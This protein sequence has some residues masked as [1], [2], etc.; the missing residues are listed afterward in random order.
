[1]A[2]ITRRNHGSRRNY[3]LKL[4]YRITAEEVERHRR[5]QGGVCSICL[6]RKASHVDHDH[7]TGL[8]RG[9]LCFPCNGALGQYHDTPE[10]LRA[11][12]R[13][14]EGT[15]FHATEMLLEFGVVTLG[16][17]ARRLVDGGGRRIKRAGTS[18]DDHLR[19]RYGIG[20]EQVQKLLALQHGRCAAC[21]EVKAEHVDHDH[22]TGVVR[23][24]LCGGCNSGMGQLADD[25]VSLRRAADYVLGQ[26]VREVPDGDGGTRF[27]LTFPDVDPRTVRPG[28]WEPYR[29]KDGEH[30]KL[31]LEIEEEMYVQTRLRMLPGGP[32]VCRRSAY[33]GPPYTTSDYIRDMVNGNPERFGHAS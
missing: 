15:G 26:L 6:R 7:D 31:F 12:A 11:A 27:S 8:F 24:I 14:L 29:V 13:Y 20:E 17:H 25:P 28:G 21:A 23:G 30:R 5:A 2:E 18:R 19:A 3:L 4:R 10:Y 22:A 9:L 16:G 33:T 32:G 1:M